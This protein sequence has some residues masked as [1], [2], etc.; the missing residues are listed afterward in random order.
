MK[1]FIAMMALIMLGYTALAQGAVHDYLQI[2]QLEDEIVVV[3]TNAEIR[4][5][6]FE[7]DKPVNGVMIRE[8]GRKALFAVIQEYESQGW[9]LVEVKS[10]EWWI[11]R[12]PKQ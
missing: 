2:V 1:K 9:V 10:D 11:M 4:L 6:P 12:K 3:S 5:V 8:R 7:R